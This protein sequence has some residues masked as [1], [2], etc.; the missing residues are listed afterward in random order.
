VKNVLDILD[1]Q[2]T[3]PKDVKILIGE[4]YRE[5][6]SVEIIRNL[7]GLSPNILVHDWRSKNLSEIGQSSKGTQIE[8]N[9]TLME[10]ETKIVIGDVMLNHF[11]GI[12]GAYS[13]LLPSFAGKKTIIQNR[14]LSLEGPVFSGFCEGNPVHDD[15]MEAAKM[16]NPDFS[17]NLVTNSRGELLMASSGDI[18]KAWKKAVSFLDNSFRI[19]ID[20]SPEIIVVSS[21]G[22]RYDFD[23]YNSI[24]ALRNVS[25]VLD[26]KGKI[27]FLTECSKG[28][29][30]SAL[31]TLS[32]INQLNELRR[33]YLLGAEAVYLMKTT[34]QK[35]SLTIVSSLPNYLLEPL[36]A[37]VD[38]IASNAFNKV[39]KNEKKDSS[40]LVVTQG[41][42]TLLTKS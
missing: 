36:G 28:L 35:N 26:K 34:T 38:R 25:N 40:V 2:N 23:L 16:T 37:Q 24:W 31:E 14:R 19:E 21:G 9:K 17:I 20:E 22:E 10:A 12:K 13:T 6:S 18:E 41:C 32:R 29:G 3:P 15:V 33:R 4:G 27:I 11:S 1:E 8:I 30:A 39:F 5:G 7:N 42:S